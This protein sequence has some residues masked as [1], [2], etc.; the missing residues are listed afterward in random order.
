MAGK[1]KIQCR[2]FPKDLTLVA[3]LK[4]AVCAH[5]KLMLW[6][7]VFPVFSRGVW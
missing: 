5:G 2:T 6:D 7:G 1:K 3:R 4:G